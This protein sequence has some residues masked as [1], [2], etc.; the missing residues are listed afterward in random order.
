VDPGERRYPFP[1]GPGPVHVA[2]PGPLIRAAAEDVLG[3]VPAGI[4][5]AR[6]HAAL[7][8]MVGELARLARAAT[9]VDVVGLTGGVFQNALLLSAATAALRADGHTVLR[10]RLVPPND[11][12]LCLGQVL[13]AAVRSDGKG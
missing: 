6:F 10:H 8:G 1:V 9:G 3:G 5:A 12:G 7:A 13:V 11:G 2:D 4:V